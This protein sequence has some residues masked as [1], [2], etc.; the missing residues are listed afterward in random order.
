MNITLRCGTQVSLLD[1]ERS[2]ISY[3]PCGQ[4]DGKDQ[5]L[6]SFSHLWG[7]RSRVNRST[8]G[9]RWNPYTTRDMNGVQLMTGLPTYRRRD[10]DYLYY[11]SIDIEAHM[12]DAY[13]EQV[14][15]IQQIYESSSDG[16]PCVIAT[17]S[18]GLRFD[19]Y[20]PY[21]GK[22]MSFK[23]S[24]GMLLE[25]LAD[26][27]LVRV[28]NRYAMIS[29]SI[30]DMPTLPKE[31]LQDIYYIIKNLAT[32]EQ[33]DNSL[34]K[35][36]EKSQLGD[37]KIEWGS[38]GRSQMFPTQHCQRTVHKSNR[39]EVRFT[40]H[41]DGSIDGKC[42][43]CGEIWWENPPKRLRSAPIRLSVSDHE[44][45]TEDIE[46]Q[47]IMI[48][49]KLKDWEKRTRNS[50]G[51]IVN[52][53]TAAG[54][55]KTT[56][57]VGNTEELLYIAKTIE[58]ADQAYS[59]ANKLG[60]V[61]WR[62]RSRIFNRDHETWEK[63]PLGLSQ[64]QRPCKYPETCN[65]LAQRGYAPV[66]TFCMEHCDAYE[67]CKSDAF[68]SQTE[69]ERQT[70][71]VFMSQT[72]SVFSDEI[73]KPRIERILNNEKILALD[74][75]NPIYLP[76]HRQIISEEMVTLLEAWRLPTPKSAEI[77]TIL[78]MLIES[79]STAKEPEQIQESFQK[80]VR[81][82]TEN[83]IT[84][85]DNKLSKIP[86]GV[87]WNKTEKH[88]LEALLI[89]GDTE[90]RVHVS[91]HYQSPDGFDGTIST[92]FAENGVRLQEFG[93]LTVSLNTFAE[94]GF[95]DLH[96]DSGDVPR[97]FTSLFKDIKTFVESGST[98]CQR[99]AVGFDFYLS[100]GLNAPRGITLTA[101]DK[102]D[103]ISEV[104]RDTGIE[105]ETITGPPPPFKP[106]CKYYQISTGRYTAKSSLLKKENDGVFN[107]KPMMDRIAKT[108]LKIA[109]RYQVLIV[110][111]KDILKIPT[112]EKENVVPGLT[113]QLHLTPNIQLINHHHA[114]G[115][116][117]Y[118]HCDIVCLFHFEPHPDEIQ[119][120]AR[121]VH[122]TADLSFKRK[123]M[124]VL[125]DGVMLTGATRYIDARVQAVYDRECE[126]RH[127]QAIMRLRPMI[128]PDKIILSF[129][130]EPV[131]R[132]PI[133][134][135]P[136]MLPELEQFAIKENGDIAA[137]DDWLEEKAQ[138]PVEKIAEQEGIK[139]R[140]AYYR[141]EKQRAGSK[142]ERNTK[143][144]A[145][146]DKGLKQQEIAD[147]LSIGLATVN[148]ILKRIK[149]SKI[150]I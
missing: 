77:Y 2:H 144:K 47:R 17:K 44:H 41:A 33:S 89:Y 148:R 26:K 129:S 74:E 104:Y 94:A 30:L 117:D 29:G 110:A 23:D 31:T 137:F 37:L 132:V 57:M 115:R 35:V 49:E 60:N 90:K 81:N 24:G 6:L 39:D 10:N 149:N 119:L 34:R 3:V 79:L 145:L 127:M 96:K 28:D 45:K 7:K 108:I 136:F 21:S 42:F 114:E 93:L 59:I 150:A 53:T 12:I 146:H 100:P 126:A 86:L 134:P 113:E 25:V 65:T 1:I 55:G 83:E 128:N 143:V 124:D 71:K 112:T 58:E 62:H 50:E 70:P 22:K 51:K 105:V 46:T 16:K 4:V 72:E 9:K 11:T 130:A 147:E 131:S 116:N 52:V 103:L 120:S 13:P 75:A 19:A 27:C 78:K 68:L 73:H 32:E 106:G 125:V 69:I 8:Y 88:G 101:S 142:M 85:I 95:V 36:V 109:E 64:D 99:T 63:L 20:T 121:C 111:P 92:T 97:H 122:P 102:D 98:A 135:M 48:A 61:A 87:V 67:T 43:N 54:T 5:P 56:I 141:T 76:Q 14:A 66:P 91:D 107:R 80:L 18:G 139:T 133:D 140:A 118:Q 15:E 38:D 40:K 138:Q 84:E 82:L 123:S